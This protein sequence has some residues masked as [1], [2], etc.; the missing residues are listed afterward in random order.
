MEKATFVF[1]LGSL[2]LFATG[3]RGADAGPHEAVDYGGVPC[4]RSG[5]F[6]IT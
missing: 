6:I 5:S 4:N 3:G 1:L 2:A